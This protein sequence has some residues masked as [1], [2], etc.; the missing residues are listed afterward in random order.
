MAVAQGQDEG[1]IQASDDIHTHAQHGLQP[2]QLHLFYI[3]YGHLRFSS[4]KEKSI[5]P[6]KKPLKLL[7]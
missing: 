4:L 5:I 1:E 7:F 2:R 3:L 6:P